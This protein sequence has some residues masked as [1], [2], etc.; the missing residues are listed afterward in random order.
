M[1]SPHSD[2][3]VAPLSATPGPAIVTI[4][5]PFKSVPGPEYLPDLND[6]TGGATAAEGALVGIEVNAEPPKRSPSTATA[7]AETL[8]CAD[9]GSQ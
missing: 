6:V 2:H 5:L 3:S 9:P 7:P 8:N 1:I 4:A